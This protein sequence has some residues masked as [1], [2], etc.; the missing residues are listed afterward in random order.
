MTT[1]EILIAA[2]ALIDTP[3]KWCQ[4]DLALDKNKNH[5]CPESPAAVQRCLVGALCAVD[6]HYD[7]WSECK[8]ALGF[9]GNPTA[10]VDFNNTHTHAEVMA[11]FDEAIAACEE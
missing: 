6:P 9:S 2:K 3:E 5:V 10:M 1:K 4:N 7:Y 8:V 11:K